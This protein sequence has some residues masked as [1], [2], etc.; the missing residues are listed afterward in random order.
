MAF[1]KLLVVCLALALGSG[2][3]FAEPEPGR[4]SVRLPAGPV[5]NLWALASYRSM[6]RP[7]R[8]SYDTPERPDVMIMSMQGGIGN[9]DKYDHYL[10]VLSNGTFDYKDDDHVVSGYYHER[11][12]TY[13]VNEGNHRIAAAL[14]IAKDTGN[15][16]PFKKLIGHGTWSITGE[17]P[18]D[19]YRVHV[20]STWGNFIS[21]KYFT[22]PITPSWAA[23][24]N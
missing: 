20:R 9:W 16:A 5:C 21:W 19:R 12:R 2:P 8:W 24:H 18:R 17:L 23:L 14:Q 6:H 4:D 11:S 22:G 10:K 15:W 3:I 13:F 1:G 7:F